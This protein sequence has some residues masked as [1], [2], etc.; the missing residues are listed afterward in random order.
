MKQ[1]FA[2]LL[3]LGSMLSSAPALADTWEFN[4]DRPG[5]D[6]RNFDLQSERPVVC[7][8]QCQKDSR[9]RA[10]TYVRPGIQGPNPRCWLKHRVPNPVRSNCC[11]SGII[12]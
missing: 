4:W 8:W 2:A 5:F 1:L 7:Q 3:L 12:Q 11:T 6:Y 9:C 10:W